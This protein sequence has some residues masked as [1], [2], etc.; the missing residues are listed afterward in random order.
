MNKGHSLGLRYTCFLNLGTAVFFFTVVCT[1]AA[2]RGAITVP[3]DLAQLSNAADKIIQARVMYAIVEPHSTYHHLRTVRVTLEI[4]DVLK[5]SAAGNIT[6]RQFIWDPRDI[7]DAAGY[8]PGNEMLLFLNAPTSL[9]LT[10]PVGL[11]QGRFRVQTNREGELVATNGN[12]NS[13]L[14]S[15]AV[16]QTIAKNARV[17]ATSRIT[18]QSFTAGPMPL[19]AL[20]ESIRAL[21]QNQPRAK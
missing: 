13:G 6:F 20:K 10:S 17:S 18:V 2:Q 4:E 1:A 16:R 8:R 14:L 11:E 19:R 5:G 21:I 9:G 7:S 12:G 15:N 3:R